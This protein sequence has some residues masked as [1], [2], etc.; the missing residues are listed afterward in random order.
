MSYGGE[1][2]LLAEFQR[3]IAGVVTVGVVSEVKG[4][5]VRVSIGKNFTPLIPFMVMRAGAV[6]V[7]CRPCV[8]EQVVVFSSSGDFSTAVAGP[9]LFCDR[10]SGGGAGAGG[11]GGDGLV[12]EAGSSVV[13]VDAGGVR[14]EAGCITLKGSV[15]VEGDVSVSGDVMAGGVSLK[16]HV[17]GGVQGGGG[18]TS[19]PQ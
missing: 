10:F 1:N 4:E 18:S 2:G 7:W 14:V 6:R 15:S 9:S 5:F 17:H 13:Y 16:S 3:Q 12:I 8:G 11:D 19:G